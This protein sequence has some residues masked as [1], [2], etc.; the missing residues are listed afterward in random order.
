[1]NTASVIVG[2]VILVFMIWLIV[3]AAGKPTWAWEAAGQNKTLY[4]VL[5]VIGIFCG[6]VGIIAGIIYLASV[7]PKVLAA[8][9]GPPPTT[10]Y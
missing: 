5:F 10:P 2:I 1:V 3:D 4:I 9:G 8:G 7:R 6:I